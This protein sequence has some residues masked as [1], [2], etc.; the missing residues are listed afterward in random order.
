MIFLMNLYKQPQ[1]FYVAAIPLLI[2]SVMHILEAVVVAC[3]NTA[4]ETVALQPMLTVIPNRYLLAIALTLSSS[5]ALYALFHYKFRH[6]LLLP[7]HF[8]VLI[9]AISALYYVCVTHLGLSSAYI[10]VNQL[11]RLGLA[12]V[13]TLLLPLYVK[14]TQS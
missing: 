5:A 11:P 12:I 1:T 13:Y 7:Q 9:A 14:P 6:Y 2:V 10:F 3:T 8:F 4:D